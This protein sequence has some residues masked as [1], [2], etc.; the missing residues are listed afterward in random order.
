MKRDFLELTD[1]P[2]EHRACSGGRRAQGQAARRGSVTTL[3]GRTLLLLFE[4][5]STRTRLSFEAAIG[6]LGGHASPPHRRQPDLPRRAADDTARVLA[7][8][9]TR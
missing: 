2:D 5:A 3:A 9:R 7:A 4:K 6:Q 8:T 1:L